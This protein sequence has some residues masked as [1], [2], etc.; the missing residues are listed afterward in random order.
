M[1]LHLIVRRALIFTPYLEIFFDFLS[2][3]DLFSHYIYEGLVDLQNIF[4]FI[5]TIFLFFT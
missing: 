2:W 3:K 1:F 5:W 4:K